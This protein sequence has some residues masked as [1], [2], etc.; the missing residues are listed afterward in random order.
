VPGDL[1]YPYYFE[2]LNSG[3]TTLGPVRVMVLLHPDTLDR[4]QDRLYLCDPNDPGC[5]PVPEPGTMLLL[6]SGLISLATVVRRRRS[7]HRP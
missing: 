4:V 1:S 3:W 6:G 7:G 2:A 5:V